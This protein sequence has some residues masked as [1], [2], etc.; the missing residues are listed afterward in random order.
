MNVE[1]N[2][3]EVH[4]R[5]FLWPIIV[6]CKALSQNFFFP[7]WGQTTYQQFLSLD[8]NRVATSSQSTP[9]E[10]LCNHRHLQI[11]HR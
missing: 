6:R 5:I 4:E 11:N 1:S 3:E 8:L 9:A 2:L 7:K 10:V